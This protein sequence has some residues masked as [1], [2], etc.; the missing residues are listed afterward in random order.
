[1]EASVFDIGAGFGGCDEV[2]NRDAVEADGEI[3]AS[4][5][6]T[7]GARALVAGALGV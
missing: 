6:D 3:G 5:R 2:L 7:L 1:M 4:S